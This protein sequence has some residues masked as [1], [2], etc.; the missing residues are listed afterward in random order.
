MDKLDGNVLAGASSGIF[1][2]DLTTS[3]GQCHFCEDIAA[4]GQAMVYGM[5]LGFVARC[6]KCGEV[7]MVISDQGGRKSFSAQGLRWLRIAGPS[8]SGIHRE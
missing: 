7:L 5:P 2:F 6:R 1:G 8:E 3:Q 4:L